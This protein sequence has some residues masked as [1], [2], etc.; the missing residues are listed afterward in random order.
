MLALG[1]PEPAHAPMARLSVSRASSVSLRPHRP[2]ESLCP[3]RLLAY[4]DRPL[5]LYRIAGTACSCARF[6]SLL[7]ITLAPP[8]ADV[9]R[10]TPAIPSNT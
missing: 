2:D 1:S 4:G 5:P 6:L 3:C 10:V 9:R 8:P 7:R